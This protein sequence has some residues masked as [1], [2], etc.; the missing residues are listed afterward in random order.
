MCCGHCTIGCRIGNFVDAVV[1][2][3]LWCVLVFGIVVVMVV[4]EQLMII[5]YYRGVDIFGSG[6]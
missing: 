6:R 1:V 2:W 4:W 5:Y 3:E